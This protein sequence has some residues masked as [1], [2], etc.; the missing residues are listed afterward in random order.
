MGT[1]SSGQ[2]KLSWPRLFAFATPGLPAGAL[3]VALT[4]FLT[5][6][7][8]GP[9]GL[10]L[11]TVGLV[12]GIVRVF[13]AFIDPLLGAIMDHSRSRFGR[14]RLW[15]AAGTPLL[16]LGVYGLF[17]PMAGVTAVMLGAWLI[18]YYLGISV[19]VLSHVS[20]ASVIAV[21]YGERARVY[22]AIQFFGVSGASLIL[23][24][25]I[26]L[27]HQ[28]GGPVPAMG[29]VIAAGVLLAGLMTLLFTPEPIAPKTD[30]DHL[31]LRDYWAILT[32][33]DVIRIGISDFC[34]TM[35]PG[36]MSAMYLFYF[37]DLRGFD[38]RGASILL[39]FYIAA[40]VFGA[41]TLTVLAQRLGKHITLMLA[42]AGYSAS[43]LLVPFV[44]KGAIA[45]AAVL[46][47]CQGFLASGFPLLDRAMM[48]DVGDQ[49]RLEL[50][51]RRVGLLFAIITTAQKVAGGLAITVSYLALSLIGYNPKPGAHNSP[52][53]IA[54]L[55]WVYLTGPIFFVGLGAALFIGYKLNAQRHGEI[56]KALAAREAMNS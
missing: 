18:V 36:W 10:G 27:A 7:Y 54:G 24:L 55:Q 6:Y 5:K 1:D 16:A 9:M 23:F 43:L 11:T 31:S 34:L 22:G 46:L 56:L 3:A 44:P 21:D 8:A 2:T 25:P 20:W 29:L 48:A 47:F 17:E 53:A 37:Q 41:P 42:A 45:I 32:R 38:Q 50:S 35:G 52:E 15:L 39:L 28:K 40:G 13:D 51:K 26:F 4:V 49:I 30:E 14:Y 33:W 19:F 12:F